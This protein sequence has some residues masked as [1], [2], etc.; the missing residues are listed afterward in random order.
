MVVEED[1]SL[2]QL[3][4]EALR[5]KGARVDQAESGLAV[6]DLF[7][8]D[9][10]HD[11]ILLDL[12]LPSVDGFGMLEWLRPY[13]EQL[14][15]L[16]ISASTAM[17]DRLTAFELGADDFLVKPFAPAELVAR[18]EALLRR[19]SYRTPSISVVADLRLLREERRAERN[20]RRIPLTAREFSILD[21]M[22]KSPRGRLSRAALLAEV[23]NLPSDATSNVLDVY[24]NYLRDKIDRPGERKLIHT[25]RGFGY[26]LRG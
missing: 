5:N 20:G 25:I 1:A 12:A 16:V 14:P 18:A 22:M 2:C 24:I 11:L 4:S 19:Q 6:R 15:I 17:E 10:T 21:H 9:I 8:S 3:L 13:H 23:W 7:G 26:E